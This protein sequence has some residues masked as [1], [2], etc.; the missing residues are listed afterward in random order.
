MF[1]YGVTMPAEWSTFFR[2]LIVLEGTLTTIA[3]G[4][5]VIDA[6]E[7]IA[8]KWVRSLINPSSVQQAVRDELLRTVPMLRRLPRHI[9]RA[10]SSME[11]D[12][13]RVRVSHF[14]DEHDERVV[15]RLVNRIVLAVLSGAI[16]LVSVGLI[17]I[18]GGPA[19][20]DSTSLFR[21]FG[22]FG[23]FCATVLAM[24]VIVAVLRDGLN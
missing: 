5:S 6:A 7:S 12:G 24:R 17:A 8:A 4:Y 15:V 18:D 23:L 22:Y 2:A 9:D 3:P 14:S 10:F 16:G 19:F 11:R 13:L 1:D 21:V 20:S